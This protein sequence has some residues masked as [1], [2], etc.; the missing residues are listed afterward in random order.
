MANML[1]IF[2]GDAFAVTTL[3]EVLREIKYQPTLIGSLGLFQTKRIDTLMVGIEK[4][5]EENEMILTALP[6]GGPGQTFGRNKRT[7]RN[8]TVPHFQVDDAVMA[9][10]VQG[11]REL[12]QTA[13]T[14]RLVREIAE[15]ASEVS[16]NFFNRTEEFHRL[17]II[18]EGKLLD[19]DGATELFDYASEFGETFPTAIEF[20]LAAAAPASGVLRNRCTGVHRSMAAALD[21]LPYTGIIGLCGDAFF[22]SLVAHTEVRETYLGW[23]AAANL[24]GAYGGNGQQATHGQFDWGDITWINYRGAGA[25]SIN[26]ENVHF[27]P[28]GVPGLFRTV[29][30][31][32]DY[33]ETV[34]MLGQRLYAKQWR[35]DNG[36]GVNLE[37]QSNALHYVT[38]PRVLLNG[39]RTTS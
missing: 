27:V 16:N 22:D 34:N 14:K 10:S 38:K 25:I 37:F 29:Y 11:V 12:G 13:A 23:S 2:S 26:T 20:D 3:T 33:I 6:R 5:P 9:D 24:R 7:M 31:P 28:R 4:A 32:A 18:T 8:L 19:S 17:K 36:K 35:M 21:G 1:D 39:I 15:R 30:G